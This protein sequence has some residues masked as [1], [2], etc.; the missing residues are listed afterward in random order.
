MVVVDLVL[1][2]NSYSETQFEIRFFV[3]PII[4]T[5][6]LVALLRVIGAIAIRLDRLI[7]P[8]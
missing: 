1:L 4:G 6:S 7:P 5:P 2:S 8:I 3:S